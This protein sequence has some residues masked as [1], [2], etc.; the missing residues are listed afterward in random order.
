MGRYCSESATARHP[1]QIKL[2]EYFDFSGFC[3]KIASSKDFIPAPAFIVE[4]VS[5]R[6]ELLNAQRSR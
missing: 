2:G 6:L 4:V 5:N 3:R 1:D